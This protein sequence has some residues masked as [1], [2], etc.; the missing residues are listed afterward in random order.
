MLVGVAVVVVA[1]VFGSVC[2]WECNTPYLRLPEEKL[3]SWH[4]EERLI[5][6]FF[7]DRRAGTFVDVGASHYM[8]RSNT[9]YLEKNLGWKGIAV[10]ALSRFE[11]G[12]RANR[13]NTSFFSFFVGDRSDG[14]IEFFINLAGDRVSS[15]SEEFT[16]RWGEYDR[17]EVAT[18][19]LDDLLGSQG[20]ERIDL[21]SMDIELA[22]P[23]ALAGFDIEKFL[24]LLVCIEV[25]PEIRDQILDYFRQHDYKIVEKYVPLDST[26]LYFTPSSMWR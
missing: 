6:D 4:N 14:K 9:Y 2:S 8:E 23:M 11:E 24:P 5:R 26:N 15:F 21:L 12:Y 10:D 16:K 22:E 18:I 19:T 1:F 17:T 25:Q 7:A 20:V 13:P 3:Y